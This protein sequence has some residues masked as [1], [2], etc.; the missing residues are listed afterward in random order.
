MVWMF[1]V[2]VCV[3]VCVSMCVCSGRCLV[4]LSWRTSLLFCHVRRKSTWTDYGQ[5]ISVLEFTSSTEHDSYSQLHTPLEHRPPPLSL[6]L[7]LCLTA[8]V[9]LSLCVSVCLSVCLCVECSSLSVVLICCWICC[10][11]RNTKLLQFTH[12]HDIT[13]SQHGLRHALSPETCSEPCDMLW[14][15]YSQGVLPPVELGSESRGSFFS[16]WDILG[17]CWSAHLILSSNLLGRW[18][19]AWSCARLIAPVVTL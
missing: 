12:V 10:S 8:R 4:F 19:F 17:C 7:S 15:C 5:D 16:C 11:C 14:V 3:C 6:S 13:V 2:C 9:C 18:W 1:C